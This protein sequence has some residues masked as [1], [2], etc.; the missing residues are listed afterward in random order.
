MFPCKT[1]TYVQ[2]NIDFNSFD[3]LNIDGGLSSEDPP[4]VYNVTEKTTFNHS[5]ILRQW[6]RGKELHPKPILTTFVKQREFFRA[7]VFLCYGNVTVISIDFH[8]NPRIFWFTL[9]SSKNC[10]FINCTFQ[11]LQTPF[12]QMGR[13]IDDVR[14]YDQPIMYFNLQNTK[15]ALRIVHPVYLKELASM[16][17]TSIKSFIEMRKKGDVFSL[18]NMVASHINISFLHAYSIDFSNTLFKNVFLRST[19]ASNVHLHQSRFINGII[20]VKK[21]RK[22]N[23]TNCIFNN[24]PVTASSS[25]KTIVHFY[26]TLFKGKTVGKGTALK[27]ELC[28]GNVEI[29]W[30]SFMNNTSVRQSAVSSLLITTSQ[31]CFGFKNNLVLT[32]NCSTF[33]SIDENVTTVSIPKEIEVI[34]FRDT[35]FTCSPGRYAKHYIFDKQYYQQPLDLRSTCQTCGRGTYNLFGERSTMTR[36]SFLFHPV[37]QNCTLCPYNTICENGKV[38][39]K[40]GYWGYP[41]LRTQKLAMLP[42]PSYYCCLSEEQCRSYNTCNSFRNGRL[43]ADCLE[44]FSCDIT[45]KHRC[46]PNSQCHNGTLVFTVGSVLVVLVVMM[47]MYMKE[48]IL[49]FKRML[50]NSDEDN[51]SYNKSN[52]IHDHNLRERLLHE[53]AFIGDQRQPLPYQI[54]DSSENVNTENYR[55]TTHMVSGG[56]K[57][58]IFFYQAGV[59][60]RIQSTDKM[61]FAYPQFFDFIFT[62]FN[63][64]LDINHSRGLACLLPDMNILEAKLG[65]LGFLFIALIFILVLLVLTYCFRLLNKTIMRNV[66]SFHYEFINNDV[67]TYSYAPFAVRVTCVYVQFLLIAFSSIATFAFVTVNCVTINLKSYL[68]V[69]ASIECYKPWQYAM[70]VFIA[71]WVVPFPLSLYLAPKLLYKCCITPAQFILMLSFPPIIPIQMVYQFIWPVPRRLGNEEAIH[72]KHLL[73]VINEPFRSTAADD[74][75]KL[76]WEAVLEFRRTLL[77][78][79]QTFILS[80]IVKLYPMALLVIVF[81]LHHVIMKPFADHLLNTVEIVSQLVLLTIIFANMFWSMTREYGL[82][83]SPVYKTLGEALM[84]YE[85]LVFALPIIGLILYMIFVVVKRVISFLR[86]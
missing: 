38:R 75:E 1:L 60:I 52:N 50:S 30:C 19:R 33:H 24:F 63:I 20:S 68:Y 70:M 4:H 44:G 6:K 84:W 31:F 72:A 74:G 17:S 28:T 27:L 54:L 22:L 66:L 18:H 65:K 61:L 85:M 12:K 57:I 13:K 16:E 36:D 3:V 41:N 62:V 45:N 35:H 42:C 55:P 8:Q 73:L 56:L 2:S 69:Q 64:K 25:A 21:M 37:S 9:I 81:V 79:T 39:F 11:Q 48:I 78:V 10:S 14:F 26:Y 51:A 77:I 15:I 53:S 43:C 5:I 59:I 71:L 83:K 47:F 23:V 80:P 86:F 40:G 58:L 34:H 32:L 46:T 76:C 29:V 67:P 7:H 49:L 82:M